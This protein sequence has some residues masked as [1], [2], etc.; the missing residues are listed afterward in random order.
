MVALVCIQ[1]YWNANIEHSWETSQK[2]TLPVPQ[3]HKCA[4]CAHVPSDTDSFPLRNAFQVRKAVRRA[5]DGNLKA[6]NH[7]IALKHQMV[8][9]STPW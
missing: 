5:A 7:Y 4:R 2:L 8:W 9:P 6:A 1:V 3:G